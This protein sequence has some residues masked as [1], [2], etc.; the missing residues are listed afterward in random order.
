MN[1][2]HLVRAWWWYCNVASAFLLTLGG[3]Y[4]AADIVKMPSWFVWGWTVILAVASPAI[5][6]P[7]AYSDVKKENED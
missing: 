4:F 7:E 3:F 2:A 5:V 6:N 1:A